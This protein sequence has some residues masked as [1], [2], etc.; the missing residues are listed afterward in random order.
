M[1]GCGGADIQTLAFPSAGPLVVM[2]LL[3]AAI[4]PGFPI[5][6][7]LFLAATGAIGLAHAGLAIQVDSDLVTDEYIVLVAV[8]ALA[9]TGMAIVVRIAS[10]AERR[11]TR[12][13]ARSRD[14]IDA[15]ES[16]ERIVRRFDGS[17]SVREV[18]QDVVDDVSRE[19][20]IALVSMYLPDEQGRLS[21]V[22][23]AGYHSPFHIIEI[24]KGVIG[25]AALSLETQFV[26]DVLA[27]PDYRAARDDVRS[28]IAAPIVHDGELL[29]IVNFEGTLAGPMG[30]S[31]VALAEMMARSIAAALRSAR[32]DEERRAR[33]HAIERVLAVSRGLVSDL[34]RGRTVAAVV[35]AAADLLAADSILVAGR[36]AQGGFRVEAET[37]LVDASAGSSAGSGVSTPGRVP[38]VGR[39][40]DHYDQAALE[41]IAAGQ[42]LIRS[43]ATV[44]GGPA[45]SVM[46]LPIRIDDEVAA[47]LTATRPA[48]AAPFGDIELGIGD[49]LATQVAVA[50]RNADR[51]AQVSD[52][53]VRDPLTGL[54]NRRYFDEAVETA[55]AAARRGAIPG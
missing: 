14:R 55:F 54:L 53:A 43:A 24:G 51:H 22:G 21:M 25:R 50:L 17:R 33:L 46:A 41:A 10:D 45:R 7:G 16:L 5:A 31:H 11:A 26:P 47:V 12:L 2:A 49:L 23:V 34:D 20:H 35:D 6:L 40:L 48:G 19:F 52:A 4:T 9:T 39:V 13:A 18:I 27:D 42:H 44:G 32:L 36:D 38:S 8:I 15:L 1:I 28:E 29:G 37:G 30:T 3:F